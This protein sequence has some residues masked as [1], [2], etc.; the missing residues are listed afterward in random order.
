[1]MTKFNFLLILIFL[2]FLNDTFGQ[3]IEKPDKLKLTDF[4]TGSDLIDVLYQR[5]L[6]TFPFEEDKSH[7][8][9]TNQQFK[10]SIVSLIRIRL[11]I[12]AGKDNFILLP[13]IVESDAKILAA[14]YYYI[15]N[16]KI[17]NIKP[18]NSEIL[19]EKNDSVI[20][21]NFS[22]VI[23]DSVVIID[24][25][26]SLVSHKKESIMIFNNKNVS[27]QNIKITIDIPE[28]YTYKNVK[29]AD[30]F[31]LDIK[32]KPGEVRGYKNA[33]TPG[34]SVTGKIVADAISSQFPNAKFNPVFYKINSHIYTL[35][36]SCKNFIPANNAQAIN[37]SLINVYAIK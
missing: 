23:K 9:V 14:D 16:N 19:L 10:L 20:Y 11:K 35:S 33:V 37:L 30:C 21:T 7:A 24:L 12:A 28:I 17:K 27:Y 36:E 2:I 13:N 5:T 1:M 32:T 6:V 15:E 3:R 4:S 31:S 18:K 8:V 26:Y 29:I 34:S 22:N 25:F